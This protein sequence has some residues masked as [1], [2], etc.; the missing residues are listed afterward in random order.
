MRLIWEL[1]VRGEAFKV[2]VK[3]AFLRIVKFY[4]REVRLYEGGA[5]VWVLRI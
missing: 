2:A 3:A 5:I 1:W 4:G